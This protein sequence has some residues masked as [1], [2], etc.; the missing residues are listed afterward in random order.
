MHQVITALLV[1][2]VTDC[3][4]NA[5][6]MLRPFYSHVEL[7]WV[8]LFGPTRLVRDALARGEIALLSSFTSAIAI[9]TSPHVGNPH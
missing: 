6:A 3:I 2:N 1:D 7:Y 5:H 8:R 9:T 4:V